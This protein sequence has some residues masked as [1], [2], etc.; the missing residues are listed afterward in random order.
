MK[1]N[2]KVIAEYVNEVLNERAAS[3]VRC[4]FDENEN[5]YIIK[6]EKGELQF[7]IFQ[8]W[9]RDTEELVSSFSKET[10]S[11]MMDGGRDVPGTIFFFLSGYWEYMVPNNTDE[12]G[13]YLGTQSF[14]YK[15]GCIDVPVVDVLINQIFEELNVGKKIFYQNSKF[16]VTHD[17]DYLKRSQFKPILRDIIRNKNISQAVRRIG[18]SIRRYNPYELETFVEKEI[19]QGIKPICFMLNTI[20][21]ENTG[22]GY[23]LAKEK[24]TQKVL[25]EKNTVGFGIHYDTRYLETGLLGNFREIENFTGKSAAYGRAHYLIFDLKKSFEIYDTQGIEID[26]SGG[27]RDVVGFRF[28][29]SLPFH[30]FNFE[31]NSAYQVLEIPLIVMDGTWISL[32]KRWN[33]DELKKKAIEKIIEEIVRTE[34]LFTILWHNTSV[35]YDI[36]RKYEQWYWKLLEA[37]RKKEFTNIGL[38]DLKSQMNVSAEEN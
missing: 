32:D 28:G 21:R 4:V 13:R 14:S 18:H 30:P 37:L 11:F 16:C 22:G 19:R 6:S 27:Y 9:N 26:F 1:L 17:I 15:A 29:T 20:Q 3:G 34:G 10:L 25:K 36:W 7:P 31:T 12:L 33:S 23:I 5:L 38:K 2:S 24:A 8:F 35:E